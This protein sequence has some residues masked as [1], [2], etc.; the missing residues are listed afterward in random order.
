MYLMYQKRKLE[1]QKD[2]F[3]RQNGGAVLQQ[4]LSVKEGSSLTAKIFTVQELKRATDNFHDSLVIGRGGFGTVYKGILPDNTSVA[5]KKSKLA[6]QSQIE[7]FINEVIILSQI[8]HRNV[9]KLL[10]C[11]LETEVPLLV[12]EFVNNGTLYESIHNK[13]KASVFT[14][15]TR[16]RIATEVAG[17][18]SYLHS[19][20]SIPI[21]HRDVKSS[22]I[23]LD[24]TCT[25]KVSDFGASR[26]VPLDQVEL[27][28]MVQGTF[29]YLDPEYMQTNQLTEKSDVYSF[30]VVILE[31]LTGRKALLFDGPE[32]ERSLAMHFLSYLNEGRLLGVVERGMVNDGNKQTVKE[33]AELAARC[34]RLKGEERPGMKEVAMELEGIRMMG[35]HPWINNDEESR[36]LLRQTSCF[37]ESVD[38]MVYKDTG[39]DSITDRVLINLDDG[40][41]KE[42]DSISIWRWRAT[43]YWSQLLLPRIIQSHLQYTST[44]TLFYG[45]RPVSS[46][47]VQGGH[48]DISMSVSKICYNQPGG[49]GSDSHYLGNTPSFAI[50]STQNKFVSVG[51]DTLGIVQFEN[52]RTYYGG[53]VTLCDAPPQQDLNDKTC[54]GTGCCQVD[55]PVGMRNISV[56]ASAIFNHSNVLDFNNCSYAFVAR[57]G[58][59][60]FSVDYLR[61]FPLDTVPLVLDWT[62]SD[63][64][65]QAASATSDYACTSNTDCVHS[66]DGFGYNCK[67]KP[68]FD[69]N[70]YHPDGCHDVDECQESTN[71]CISKE[72]CRNTIGSFECFCPPGYTGNGTTAGGCQPPLSKNPL[73][74]VFIGVSIGLA[75]LFMSL[76]WLYLVSQKRKLIKQKEKF[77]RQNGGFIL[78]QRLSG[79]HDPSLAVKIFSAEE[80]KRATN[81]YHD[82]LI[83]GRGGFGTVYKGFLPGKKIVAIKKSKL[84]NQS[85]V[86]QFINEVTV[87][88]QINHRNIVKLLGCCLE[89]EVPL[90]VYEFINNGTL[91]DLMHDKR[92]SSPVTWE[93]RLRIASEVAGALSYLHSAA[94]IPIVHRDIKSANILLDESLTAKVSDFGASRLVPLDQTGLATMVQGTFGYLDPEYM[95]TNQLTEKSDVYSFGVV[96]VELLTGK[97]AVSFERPEEEVNLAMHFLTYLNQGHL[98]EVVEKGVMNDENKERVKEVAMLAAGCVRLRGEERPS[99]KE[100][101]GELEGIKM[102]GNQLGVN[103]ELNLEEAQTL[104]GETSNF[105]EYGDSMIHGNRV[106]D[107]IKDH[108]L[109]N[110]DSGR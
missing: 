54:S 93:T 29:G 11:C 43:S 17:A 110:L 99:M 28:T 59:F 32:E 66:N 91:F 14:W 1:K 6:D 104:L 78:Q 42:G 85:Q 16:L 82:N 83:I 24:D 90:L 77:F 23:L 94:S 73:T 8:N 101:A 10:G 2:K 80:L 106:W 36:S 46:I 72:N 109:I 70:P 51:C 50:S 33:V 79:G 25:A 64:T 9:V 31:L 92:K 26:L 13:S 74:M 58:W 81:N 69:G 35:K 15:E 62:V 40:R 68:G 20:A 96:L 60:N 89:T 47:S 63:D 3:F 37:T 67:C 100:V 95:Q 57:Q 19:A 76:S 34:L 87:L 88:S 27:A 105:T 107:S 5:I 102:M 86:E 18:L 7:Q 75:A 41:L 53:C 98:D 48:L 103:K 4:K 21:I 52:N 22:N 39:W 45:D 71:N 55:I 84:M 44:S 61:D 30:G 12:Y 56:V 65:C 49:A 38:S 108:V 97:K